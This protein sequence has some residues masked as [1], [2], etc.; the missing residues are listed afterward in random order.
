MKLPTVRPLVDNFLCRDA[1]EFW[2][3]VHKTLGHGKGG[4]FKVFGK[5]GGE[6]YYLVLLI[7][8]EKL[9]GLEAQNVSS[10]NELT[11]ETAL[12]ILKELLNGPLIVDAYPLDEIELKLSI[13]DNVDVYTQT[14]KV[15]LEGMLVGRV[16]EKEP[17]SAT[18]RELYTEER[19][20]EEKRK[21]EKLKKTEVV[22]NVPIELDPYFRMMVKRLK[23]EARA[24][25]ANIKRIEIEAREVRYALGAGVGVHSSLKIYVEA[26][27]GVPIRALREH[28]EKITYEEAGNI[29]SEIEK[30]VV[31][32]R[33]DVERA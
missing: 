27:G 32:S 3:V 31:V 5:V 6:P 21:E 24:F 1:G 30:R 17:R 23:N 19:E 20:K 29:S 7:D 8:D 13:A 12:R 11:G 2:E 10:G 28:L 25:N 15:T 14:P 16:K 9:L 33:V 4:I 18:E 26:P 22:L